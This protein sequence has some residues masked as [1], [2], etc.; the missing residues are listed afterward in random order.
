MADESR[1]LESLATGVVEG[2]KEAT[3]EW[4]RKAVE[5]GL[6]PLRVFNES[7]I[8]AIRQVGDAFGR[9]DLFLPELVQAGEAL[10]AAATPLEEEMRRKGLKRQVLATIVIGT[11][12]GDLHDIGKSIVS[13]IMNANSFR[14]IDLGYDVPSAKF[15]EAVKEHKPEFL[16]MSSLLTTS[17][18]FMG[19]VIEMLSEAGLRERVKIIL[20]GS[21][22][23]QE[24]A[25]SIGAD[26]YGIDAVDAVEKLRS[27]LEV[28]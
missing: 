23:T 24:F 25:N 21:P 13:A 2:D 18:P 8:P 17:M 5:A 7:L 6:D 1:I 19:E 26:L 11:V 28:A 22:V 16:G 10:K 14:V 15:I 3:A 4:G 20:G 9:G 27:V 12:S